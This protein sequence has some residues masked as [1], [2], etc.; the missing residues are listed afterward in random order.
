MAI[1]SLYEI[2]SSDQWDWS[3]IGAFIDTE[4]GMFRVSSDSG[5]SCNWPWDDEHYGAPLTMSAAIYEANRCG[6][7]YEDDPV[8][9]ASKRQD[10]KRAIREADRAY[11]AGKRD[12]SQ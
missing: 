11:K 3:A 8:S 4:T 5:C 6:F 10:M 1:Q 9:L 2:H 12:F 7:S